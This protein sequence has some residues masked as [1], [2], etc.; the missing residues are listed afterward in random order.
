MEDLLLMAE[1]E[2]GEGEKGER[3]GGRK[4]REGK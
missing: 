3:G 2:V 4:V 1:R